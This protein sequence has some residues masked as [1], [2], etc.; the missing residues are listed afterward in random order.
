VFV[1]GAVAEALC[2]AH[3]STLGLTKSI[4]IPVISCI[5]FVLVFFSQ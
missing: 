4:S 1:E 5:E 2:I 3:A